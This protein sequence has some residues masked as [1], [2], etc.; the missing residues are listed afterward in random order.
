MIKAVALYTPWM[1]YSKSV[2]CLLCIYTYLLAI[3][4]ELRAYIHAYVNVHNIHNV[5]LHYVYYVHLRIHT[6][7]H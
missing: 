4:K 7:W 3:G 1:I 2:T 5:N 6:F